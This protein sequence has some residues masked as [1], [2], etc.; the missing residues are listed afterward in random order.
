M[1]TYKKS[2]EI[3]ITVDG[4]GKLGMN[5]GRRASDGAVYVAAVFESALYGCRDLRP[6]DL[7]AMAPQDLPPPGGERTY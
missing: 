3:P 7:L 1:P 2:L 6:G 4:A 5:I